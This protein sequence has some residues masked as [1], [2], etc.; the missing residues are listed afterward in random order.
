M[1]Y[2]CISTLARRVLNIQYTEVR[3]MGFQPIGDRILAKR[4]EEA[5]TT[6][7]GIIIPD[8]AK[9]KPLQ[10]E[11]VEV[12]KAVETRGEIKKGDTIYIGQYAGNEIKLDG[13][14]FIVL[15]ASEKSTD[16]LGIHQCCGGSCS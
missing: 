4:K 9:E 16:I 10:V 3:N 6:A 15:D 11:V 7:S 5:K 2:N 13:E 8:S 1:L 12:S 14:T